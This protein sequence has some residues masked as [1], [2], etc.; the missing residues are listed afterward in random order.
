M[1]GDCSA[2][3][4]PGD[5]WG[6][7]CAL[8]CL[9]EAFG[10]QTVAFSRGFGLWWKNWVPAK[11]RSFLS[12]LLFQTLSKKSGLTEKVSKFQRCFCF[13]LVS[14]N[15]WNSAC[16]AVPAGVAVWQC[17]RR[18]AVSIRDFVC[19]SVP[20]ACDVCLQISY[21]KCDWSDRF[22]KR[23]LFDLF[24]FLFCGCFWTCSF[25]VF[26]QNKQDKKQEQRCKRKVTK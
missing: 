24:G 7:V 13:L 21:V 4:Q 5:I 9:C 22:V 12:L 11:A 18:L 6:A 15:I 8:S 20:K 25:L 10:P 19:R 16:E 23:F 26:A 17:V 2:L 3:V 14:A 1:E